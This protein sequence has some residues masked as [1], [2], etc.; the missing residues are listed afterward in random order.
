MTIGWCALPRGRCLSNMTFRLRLGFVRRRVSREEKSR[1]VAEC[2][3]PGV[4]LT[5]V[6]R[7]NRVALDCLRHWAR[8]AGNAGVAKLEREDPDA[9][10]PFIPLLVDDLPSERVV[11]IDADGVV[12]RLPVDSLAMRIVA[13]AAYL[14]RLAWPPP[15]RRSASCWPPGGSA[16]T[17]SMMVWRQWWSTSSAQVPEKPASRPPHVVPGSA[18]P[19]PHQ[20]ASGRAT[21]CARRIG[22]VRQAFASSVD[23][24][25]D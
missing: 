9:Q 5:T 18:S 16:S 6:A 17:K 24:A 19:R 8:L 11:T 13:V 25:A 4:Y 3:Q 15:A 21:H 20:A 22:L 2:Q 7:R 23:T 14:R 1:I 10:P 12:V